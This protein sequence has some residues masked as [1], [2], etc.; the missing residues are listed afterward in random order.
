MK[1]ITL[2]FFALCS[3]ALYAQEE[4]MAVVSFKQ[5]LQDLAAHLPGQ[6][7]LRTRRKAP[8]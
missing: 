1:K 2:L 6:L 7:Y 5:D 4:G 8:E 3:L